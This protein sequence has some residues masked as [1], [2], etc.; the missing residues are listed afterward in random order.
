MFGLVE[1]FIST[2]HSPGVSKVKFASYIVGDEG[3]FTALDW[4]ASS[5]CRITTVIMAFSIASL[6]DYEVG[7][8]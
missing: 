2:S 7:S 5:P 6:V 1:I 4:K 8:M 3:E